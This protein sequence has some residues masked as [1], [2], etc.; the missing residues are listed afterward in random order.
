MCS[1]ATVIYFKFIISLLMNIGVWKS[2]F[3]GALEFFSWILISK[4]DVKI[5]FRIITKN[6]A[7][8]PEIRFLTKSISK[9]YGRATAIPTAWDLNLHICYTQIRS[10]LLAAL[11]AFLS[12]YFSDRCSLYFIH[13]I[14]KLSKSFSPLRWKIFHSPAH[15][16]LKEKPNFWKAHSKMFPEHSLIYRCIQKFYIFY[17]LRLIYFTK[18]KIDIWW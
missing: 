9:P 7:A 8:Y 10:T 1:W 16:A 6:H 5:K 3:F 11:R 14:L 2:N 15:G 13:L 12:A 18:L 4:R 17:G